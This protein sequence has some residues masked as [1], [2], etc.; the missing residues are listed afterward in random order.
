[1]CSESAGV[2]NPF[3]NAF[4]VEVKNL[5]AKMKILQSCRT[6]NSYFQRILIVPYG[7][8][9][10]GSQLRDVLLGGLMRLATG[11]PEHFLVRQAHSF[12]MV[13]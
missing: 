11:S 9:L 6:S 13:I 12:A 4:V 10:L 8:S 7:Y 1:M 5:L 2:D 3:R